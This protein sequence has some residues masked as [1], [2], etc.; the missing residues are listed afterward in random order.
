V[1]AAIVQIEIAAIDLEYTIGDAVEQMPVVGNTQQATLEVLEALLEPVDR[2]DVEM[3]RGFV[4]HEKIGWCNQ[5]PSECNAPLLTPTHRLDLVAGAIPKTKPVEHCSSFPRITNR[6][7]RR[8]VFEH[9][10]LMQGRHLHAALL[11]DDAAIGFDCPGGDTE[12][13]RFARPVV[14]NNAKTVAG[15]DGKRYAGEHVAPR[16]AQGHIVNID[17]NHGVVAPCA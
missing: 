3:V 8:D 2:V 13:R 9:W 14:A 12:Q 7:E 5:R 11:A 17:E 1:V 10:A 16:M 15:A 4:E 6:F